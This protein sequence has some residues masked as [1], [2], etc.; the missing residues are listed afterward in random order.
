M[1]DARIKSTA[2]KNYLVRVSHA[3]TTQYMYVPVTN[4]AIPM[5][6]IDV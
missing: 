6:L 1:T 5:T 4:K 3:A 2:P